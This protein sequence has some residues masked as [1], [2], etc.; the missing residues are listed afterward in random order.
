MNVASG[1]TEYFVIVRVSSHSM[2][3][4]LLKHLKSV[5]SAYALK[6]WSLVMSPAIFVRYLLNSVTS[7]RNLLHQGAR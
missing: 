6:R 5:M 1:I 7:R 4:Y 2:A 3:S